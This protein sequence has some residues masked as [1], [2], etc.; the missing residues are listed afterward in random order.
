MMPA[1]VIPL[2]RGWGEGDGG[3]I[4]HYNLVVD[5]TAI[6]GEFLFIVYTE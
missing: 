1:W 5:V 3:G 4:E 2:Y 6:I